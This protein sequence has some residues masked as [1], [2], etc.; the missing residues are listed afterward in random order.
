MGQVDIII[1]AYGTE[2]LCVRS[3][4]VGANNASLLPLALW[5]RS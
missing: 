4:T 2:G 1:A 5:P 3:A